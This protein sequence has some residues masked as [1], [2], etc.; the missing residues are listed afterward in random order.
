MLYVV[1]SVVYYFN[2]RFNKRINHLGKRE[3]FLCCPL[4]ITRNCVVFV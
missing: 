3:L 4:H 1:N 2:I